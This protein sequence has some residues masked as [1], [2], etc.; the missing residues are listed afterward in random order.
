MRNEDWLVLHTLKA[1]SAYVV[2]V[3]VGLM[4]VN[5]PIL[6]LNR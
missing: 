3:M 2:L 4:Y 1:L 5:A 6:P